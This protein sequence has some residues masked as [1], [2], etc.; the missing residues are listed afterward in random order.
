MS[1]PKV[2]VRGKEKRKKKKKKTAFE[3]QYLRL[4]SGFYRWV[5]SSRTHRETH[6]REREREGGESLGQGF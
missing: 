2:P 5:S 6:R 4:T 3:R 1:E